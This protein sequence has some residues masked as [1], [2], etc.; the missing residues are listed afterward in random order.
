[1]SKTTMKAALFQGEGKVAL[2]E[3][4]IPSPGPGEALIRV[5][6]AGICGTDLHIFRGLHPR[7]TPPLVLS[8]EFAGE[9]VEAPSG[10]GF[11][12]GDRVV[13]NP[14]LTCGE[15]YSCRIGFDHLCKNINL[16]GIDVHGG[17]AE[18]T[19]AA[20]DRLYRLPSDMPLDRASAVEPM[21]V[22]YRGVSLM[23]VTLGDSAVVLGGG[24][25]GILGAQALRLAGATEIMISEINPFRRKLAEGMG[26]LT[27]DPSQV[28]AVEAVVSWTEG[29]G[30]DLVLDAAAVPATAAQIVPI[31]RARGEIMQLGMHWGKSVS[32]DLGG[33]TW[34]EI[35]LKGSHVYTPTDFQ[36]SIQLIAQERVEVDAILT[37]RLPLEQTQQGIELAMKGGDSMK[38]LIQC[39]EDPSSR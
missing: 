16:I 25:I 17:T 15:C 27:I 37:P 36:R 11:Q 28:D 6:Y 34:Y 33:I 7:A 4:P 39:Q 22:A 14:L 19:T 3:I 31:T 26:F 29:A 35:V 18:Y 9:V 10:S 5:E 13:V 2:E 38:V 24:P 12:P 20:V 32:I 1:M 23:N 8:H 21:A 30:A